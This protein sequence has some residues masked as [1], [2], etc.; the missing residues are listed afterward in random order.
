METVGIKQES[1]Y[2]ETTRHK[3]VDNEKRE[4]MCSLDMNAEVKY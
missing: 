4:C 1:V 2:N 3:I